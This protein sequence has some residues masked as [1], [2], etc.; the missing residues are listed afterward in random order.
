[1]KPVSTYLFIIYCLYDA[2]VNTP[3]YHI[4]HR[5]VGR[6][7]NN[8]FWKKMKQSYRRMNRD[9]IKAFPLRYW[10]KPRSFSH[11]SCFPFSRIGP[12]DIKQKCHA[13]DK[14]WLLFKRSKTQ[15]SCSTPHSKYGNFNF[16]FA[17]GTRYTVRESQHL[18]ENTGL[19][20]KICQQCF[21]T[22][23]FQFRNSSHYH[24][25]SDN[26]CIWKNVRQ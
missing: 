26:I 9:T 25:T 8:G 4:E 20:I 10:G 15:V 5:M 6:G 17:H 23:H 1:M 14:E 3:D 22:Q 16:V 7:V 12:Q 11:H 13:L 19:L 2:R 24:F 21:N 18:Q